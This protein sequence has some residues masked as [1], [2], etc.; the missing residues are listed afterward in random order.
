MMVGTLGPTHEVWRAQR[1]GM[2]SC[3]LV[4]AVDPRI[5]EDDGLQASQVPASLC[6][7][8]GFRLSPE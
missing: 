4:R 6:M 5:R 8:S 2:L 1:S 7:V 3:L